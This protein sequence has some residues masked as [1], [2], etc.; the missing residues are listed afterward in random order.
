MEETAAVRK[1]FLKERQTKNYN[2]DKL[3]KQQ[4]PVKGLLSKG[5]RKTPASKPTKQ[6]FYN[7]YIVRFCEK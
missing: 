2:I 7:Q 4:I 3:I 6:V 1:Y 5:A